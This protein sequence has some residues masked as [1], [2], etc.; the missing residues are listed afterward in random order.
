MSQ[1]NNKRTIVDLPVK[2]RNSY[3]RTTD[4]AT[5]LGSTFDRRMT[6]TAQIG[7]IKGKAIPRIEVLRHLTIQGVPKRGLRTF[8]LN[9][10]RPVLETGYHLTHDHKKSIKDLEKI[11]NR[12][13]RWNIGLHLI[14]CTT[15]KKFLVMQYL[16]LGI[17]VLVIC[18]APNS[19]QPSVNTAK[20][21]G[22][23]VVYKQFLARTFNF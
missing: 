2:I 18:L 22:Q 8:Y 10:I 11:Q 13:G 4:E 19:W 7:K 15:I 14:Q 23:D 21:K 20:S 12:L 6:R 9:M 5:L 16:R 3:I 17:E 1:V